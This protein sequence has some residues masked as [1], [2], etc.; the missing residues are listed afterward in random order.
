[1]SSKRQTEDKYRF[2]STFRPEPWQREPWKDTESFVVLYTG[3]AG[4][5]KSRLAAERIHGFCLRYPGAQ[6]LV[7]RKTAQSLQN[8]VLLL[9]SRLVI[10]DDPRVVHHP[11]KNRFEY[12]NGSILSY[13]GMKDESQREY[14][15]SIGVHGGVDMCWM[16]EA[17]QFQ[18]EDF[19]EVI[20][21]MRGKAAPWRQIMLTTNPDHPG[22]WINT[23]LIIGGEATVY[24]SSA[25]DNS[26]NP[27]SY[28]Q[29]L[30]T[31]TGVQYLRLVKGQWVAGSSLVYDTWQDTFNVRTEDDGGGNVTLDA[32]YIP[33]SGPVYW[34]IDDGYSGKRDPNTG[35][36]TGRSHPRVILMAQERTDGKLAIFA[37]NYAIHRLAKDHLS[38]VISI[39]NKNEW[40]MPRRIIRDRAAASLGGAIKEVLGKEP[41]YNT[42]KVEESIKEVRDWISADENGFRRLIVHP[43]C[44]HLRF[45]F[46]SY[47]TD[48]NNKPIKEHDNGPDALRYLVWD[49]AYGLSS[50][51]DIATLDGIISMPA[52][53]SSKRFTGD[54]DVSW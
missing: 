21:R 29:S 42:T 52:G 24:Y 6:G 45:E 3:S 39:C 34:A 13:G 15:R 14:I 20:S 25:A 33:D 26:H 16:E 10:S 48:E 43:R 38:E 1:M 28:V 5:G 18:E 53:H 12:S 7:L 50:S 2:I 11:G 23:R 27:E 19:N 32:E 37:E 22:H 17:N 49:T 54:V 4:G 40:P 41:R 44:K 51:V 46:S 30:E 9:L 47:S 31:L 36:F 35:M 8:S